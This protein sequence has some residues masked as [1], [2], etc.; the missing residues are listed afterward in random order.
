MSLLRKIK[1]YSYF[2]VASYFRFWAGMY[3]CR[4]NPKV[5]AVIGSSGKTTL[6]HLF[7]AQLG[8]KARY[9]HHANSAFGIPFHILGL[10][11]KFFSI[12]EWPLFAILAPF[13]ALRAPLKE[14]IYVAEADAERPGEG[15]F[16]AEL[17]R[18]EAT[19]WL[20]L[21]EAHG[22]NYDKL[23]AHASGDHRILVKQKMAEEFGSFLEYTKNF[24]VLNIDNEYI[25]GQSK[26]TK[27]KVVSVSEKEIRAFK[28]LHESVEVETLLGDF[29][30]P[31]L[32][33]FP[34]ALS[35]L[36]V[37]S[38]LKTLGIEVESDFVHFSLP[39]G[40]SSVFKG[41][42]DTTLI[43][44]TYNATMDGMRAMLDLVR[45]YL[46][47]TQKWLVLG[48]MIEQGK[49]E[50]AEH[51]DIVKDILAVS[52]ARV[53]LVGPRLTKYTYPLLVKALGEKNVV[54]YLMPG[55]ALTYLKKELQGGETILLKGARYLEGVVEKLL[56]DPKDASKLCRR[57]A[58]WVEQ[59]KK[60][61]I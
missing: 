22:V 34:A 43:D 5:I 21:E 13:K 2:F 38:T 35:V 47:R 24:C 36:A 53:I 28:I 40:R 59:R 48:D 17:L 6:L 8:D 39:P 44:S 56:T 54:A 45:R 1:R 50:E 30:L 55:E 23:V 26:R 7:E 49:S 3:L 46:V 31:S 25:T 51:I 32:L 60:W 29:K 18:P 12:F 15:K 61:G 41:I 9:S 20:S 10:E 19:V 11:R 27:S 57:E 52:P 16:L 37:A 58:I 14:K 33:P 42:R 4:W